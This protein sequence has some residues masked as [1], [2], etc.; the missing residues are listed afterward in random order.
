MLVKKV[1]LFGARDLRMEESEIDEEALKKGECLVETDVSAFSTGTDLANYLGDSTYVPGA[2]DYPRQ[3]GYSNAGVVRRVFD[4][5]GLLAP[6]QRVFSIRPHQ[7]AFITEQDEVLVPIPVGV[8]SSEASLAYLTQ[9]GL[10]AL[11]RARYEAGENVLVLG[12]GVIGLCTVALARAIG[13]CVV[14]IE[15]NSELRADVA[16]TLGAQRVLMSEEGQIK[17]KTEKVFGEAGADI[18]VLTANPWAAYRLALELVRREGRVSILGFPGRGQQRPDFNPLDPRWIYAKQLTLTGA[19][20]TSSLRCEASEIR[21]NLSRNLEFV[22]GLMRDGSL[23][24]GPL[25]SHRFP[26][27][28]ARDAYELAVEHPNELVAAVFDWKD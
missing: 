22:L 18:V 26:A 4:E 21:F 14:G 2:P 12:L 20:L 10:S 24:L 17:E 27:S 5:D 15:A 23:N 6:G 1:V 9:L 16:T 7:S 3:V 13:A 28:Q 25:I 11:R 8:S 19:G